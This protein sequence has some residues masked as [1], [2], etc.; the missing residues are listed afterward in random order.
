MI[1]TAMAMIQTKIAEKGVKFEG[2][3]GGG[4]ISEQPAE[5]HHVKTAFQLGVAIT[6]K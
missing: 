1:A 5:A 4:W 2:L 6:C 3:G